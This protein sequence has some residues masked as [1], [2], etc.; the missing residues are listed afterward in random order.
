[1]DH[2]SAV[3]FDV[4]TTL[5]ALPAVGALL[6]ALVSRQ[7]PEVSRQLAVLFTLISAGSRR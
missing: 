1:M 7:R 3:D 4:L 5:I 6:I 2:G